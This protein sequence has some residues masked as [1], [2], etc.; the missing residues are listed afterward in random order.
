MIYSQFPTCCAID[1]FREFGNTASAFDKTNYSKK[2]VD[3]FLSNYVRDYGTAGMVVLNSDQYKKLK[4]VFHKHG[5]KCIKSFYYSGHN[6]NIHIMLRLTEKN[7][8]K[9]DI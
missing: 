7:N 6:K 8:F 1:L 2:Q 9:K 3:E 5:F 4:S